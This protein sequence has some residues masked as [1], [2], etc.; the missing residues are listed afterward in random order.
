MPRPTCRPDPSGALDFGADS[1]LDTIPG[2]D[3]FAVVLTRRAVSPR[4]VARPA[5]VWR[6]CQEVAVQASARS[7]WPPE[8]FTEVGAGFIVS[9]MVVEH[10]REL[11]YGERTRART[12][13]RDFRRGMVTHREIRLTGDD[14]P[15]ARATQR[16]VH[17]SRGDH[18][19]IQIGRASDDIQAAFAAVKTPA[20]TAE[21]PRPTRTTEFGR[22]DQF[23]LDVWQTW[24]DPYGHVNHPMYVDFADEAVARTAL[25]AGVDPQ[26]IFPVAERVRFRQAAVAGDRLVVETAAVGTIDSDDVVFEQVVR[27]AEDHAELARIT[28]IRGHR[29]DPEAWRQWWTGPL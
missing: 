20:P 5:E 8:R 25:D 28:L 27:R 11:S 22:T 12:W 13:I 9:D 1:V 2:V 15:L 4:G 14:G 17:V 21:V 7:G 23:E 19:T 26:G 29:S 10:F 6:M 18:G 24:M 3:A 16:W